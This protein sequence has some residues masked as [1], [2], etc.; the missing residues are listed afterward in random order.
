MKV[1]IFGPFQSMDLFF[2]QSCRVVFV[3]RV[4][5]R[6]IEEIIL[7]C[8]PSTTPSRVARDRPTA[9]L[10]TF[11]VTKTGEISSARQVIQF[12]AKRKSTQK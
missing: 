12:D 6:Q 1:G 11:S 9:M 3:R 8:K 2:R 7:S 10:H 5:C 4:R